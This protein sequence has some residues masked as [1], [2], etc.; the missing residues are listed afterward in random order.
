MKRYN[1]MD[2]GPDAYAKIGSHEIDEYERMSDVSEFLR[3]LLK[4]GYVVKLW[5]DGMTIGIEYNSGNR[6]Y[7]DPRLE[8]LSENEYITQDEPS[9]EEWT[10]E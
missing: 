8:W 4:N 3:I 7:G 5:D 1:E 10:E 9:E 2:F 6:E